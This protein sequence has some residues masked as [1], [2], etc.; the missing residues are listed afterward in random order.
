MSK[1]PKT[2]MYRPSKLPVP[3]VPD[4]VKR[5]VAEA[6]HKWV[7]TVLKPKHI[8]A[9]PKEKRFNYLV[10]IDTRWH[11]HFFYFE[12]KYA[13]P[14]PNAITPFFTAKFARLECV[15]KDRFNLSFMRHTEQWVELDQGLSLD[16]CLKA[17]ERD[18]F[19][20][21]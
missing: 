12:A 14:G 4:E 18:P 2:W 11:R 5:Q 6:S 19:F 8:K 9:P 3:K 17:I 15:G 10:D 13:C 21:P 7:D 16:Q 1:S 20:V